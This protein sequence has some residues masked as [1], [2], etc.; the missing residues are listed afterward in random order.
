M[1]RQCRDRS[2]LCGVIDTFG[3]Y[4]RDCCVQ[5]AKNASSQR[6]RTEQRASRPIFFNCAAA[7]KETAT[8]NGQVS[9]VCVRESVLFMYAQR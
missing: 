6:E 8:R 9:A 2:V 4:H 5:S 3:V 1:R 7:K